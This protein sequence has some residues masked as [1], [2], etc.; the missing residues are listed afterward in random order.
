M[1]HG[2]FI[3]TPESLLILSECSPRLELMVY[4]APAYD[5]D[6]G[7]IWK[8]KDRRI[9]HEYQDPECLVKSCIAS[10]EYWTLTC[11][12]GFPACANIDKP[13]LAMRFGNTARWRVTA[14][15]DDKDPDVYYLSVPVKQYLQDFDDLLKTIEVNIP[16]V[17]DTYE[18]DDSWI[19]DEHDRF[20]STCDGLTKVRR[21]RNRIQ[22]E[23][24][25]K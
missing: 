12:C 22:K 4:H 1:K 14:S 19:P 20:S 8:I 15:D 23:L 25:I 3:D 11:E 7:R 9:T 2:A 5:A 21:I 16:D 24:R 13:V 10:G 17:G 18:N 6:L